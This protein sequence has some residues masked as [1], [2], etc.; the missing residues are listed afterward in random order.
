MHQRLH[1]ADFLLVSF[2]EILDGSVQVEFQAFGE[3]ADERPFR[4]VAAKAVEEA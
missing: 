3:L 1:H 2:R 4:F